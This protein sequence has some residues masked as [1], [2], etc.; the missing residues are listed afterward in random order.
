MKKTMDNEKCTIPVDEQE[1]MELYR[2]LDSRGK[3]EV[4]LTAYM[5]LERM[6]DEYVVSQ[7]E[8]RQNSKARQG[9]NIINFRTSL[10]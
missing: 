6:C 4:Q 9:S 1:L 7:A 8:R 2:I 5:Q 10:V 3:H